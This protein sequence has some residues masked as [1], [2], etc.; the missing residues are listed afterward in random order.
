[1]LSLGWTDW[2]N[3]DELNNHFK[4]SSL[5]RNNIKVN[6]IITGKKLSVNGFF[7]KIIKNLYISL[8]LDIQI[9]YFFYGYN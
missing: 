2:D 1:M 6:C 9:F 5:K 7:F 8:L 3:S 4:L